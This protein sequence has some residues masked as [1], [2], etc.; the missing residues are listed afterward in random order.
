MFLALSVD[1]QYG[2]VVVLYREYDSD[3]GGCILQQSAGQ[4]DVQ[5]VVENDDLTSAISPRSGFYH[6]HL[7][8]KL[9]KLFIF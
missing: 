2:I 1:I 5:Y 3:C 9:L 7:G 6:S 4:S 8:F